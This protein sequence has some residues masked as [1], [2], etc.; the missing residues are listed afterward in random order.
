[1]TIFPFSMDYSWT[2]AYPKYR[3]SNDPL[4]FY[5]WK[6]WT[7]FAYNVL[8]VSVNEWMNGRMTEWNERISEWVSERVRMSWKGCVNVLWI[9]HHLFSIIMSTACTS[10]THAHMLSST[11]WTIFTLSIK[12]VISWVSVCLSSTY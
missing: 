12:L 9:E 5:R 1:M 3:P 10:H 11:H 2:N 8:S 7:L 4:P 6:L